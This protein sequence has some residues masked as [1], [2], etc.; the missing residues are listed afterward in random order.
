M[1]LILIVFLSIFLG[2]CEPESEYLLEI[3]YYP[4][5]CPGGCDAKMVFKEEADENGYY[6][7]YLD[8][9]GEYYPW[10]R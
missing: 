10:L 5:T 9:D 2:S 8:W 3:D 1:R 6:H 4:I 7:I